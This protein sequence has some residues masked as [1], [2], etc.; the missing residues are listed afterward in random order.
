MFG[1][2]GCLLLFTLNYN[3]SGGWKTKKK[4]KRRQW[5]LVNRAIPKWGQGIPPAV[6]KEMC[7]HAPNFALL[8]PCSDTLTLNLSG[9]LSFFF[10]SPSTK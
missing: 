8:S 4:E 2:R 9:A 7:Q 10:L 5:E 3:F 6:W 1:E